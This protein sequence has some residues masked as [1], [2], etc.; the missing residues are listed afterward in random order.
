MIRAH[1]L[2][3]NVTLV[4]LKDFL[5]PQGQELTVSLGH[6]LVRVCRGDVLLR[7]D[8]VMGR[9]LLGNVWNRFMV[10]FLLRNRL[11]RFDL[12]VRA[13][14]DSDQLHRVQRD[15]LLLLVVDDALLLIMNLLIREA[16]DWVELLSVH[17]VATIRHLLVDVLDV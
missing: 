14:C 5:V 7:V 15:W 17:L 3:E 11:E 9:P 8:P 2:A 4:R 1:C 6:L 12:V 10:F 16:V 13:V